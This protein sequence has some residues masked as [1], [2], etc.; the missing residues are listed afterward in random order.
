[1]LNI[2]NLGKYP[3]YTKIK[4]SITRIYRTPKTPKPQN[5]KTP[6]G[7]LENFIDLKKCIH[8]KLSNF[9]IRCLAAFVCNIYIAILVIS[10]K[11]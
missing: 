6:R 2:T 4:R 5:P 11:E 3:K 8:S 9:I 10:H 7:L 1:M